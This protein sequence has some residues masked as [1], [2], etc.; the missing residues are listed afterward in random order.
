MA[1]FRDLDQLVLEKISKANMPGVSLAAIK[2]N[3]VIYKRGYGLRDLEKGLPATPA[4]LY[5]IGSVTKSFTCLALMQLQERGLLSVDD[6]VSNHLDF[7]IK[8]FGE[9]VKVRHLM[10]HTSGIPALA[11]AEAVIRKSTGATSRGLSMGSVEDMLTFMEGAGDWAHAKPGERWF[12]L[13]EGYILLGAIIEKVSGLSYQEYVRQHI[14]EPLEME[15]SFFNRESL[16]EDSEAAVPYAIDQEGNRR[17]GEYLFGV[18][19]SDGGLI[20]SVEDLSRY[21]GM[22]LGSGKVDGAQIISE[23]ALQEMMAPRV[24]TPPLQAQ[25]PIDGGAGYRV[26]LSETEPARHYGYGLGM[27]DDFF[28]E[29]VISHGGSVGIATAYMAFV[30]QRSVGIALL[31]N[32]AGYP[33]GYFAEYG[34]AL[35]LG[36]DPEALSFRQAETALDG[37][38][39]TYETFKGTMQATLRRQGDLLLFEAKDK[40]S[41]WRAT[42]IPELLGSDAAQFFRLEGGYRIPVEF[43]ISSDDVEFLF[44]R[45]KFRKIGA[46]TG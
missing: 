42:L 12:Y 33:L 46:L 45:Y 13:N 5:G 34:L 41:N 11:Y 23:G 36:E 4:T 15:R 32:G 20:S 3:E 7:S 21:V 30:P 29:T 27:Q 9:D 16:E 19:S 31:S 14:L 40:L 39:G 25:E 6:K 38:E 10:S 2:D 37:L 1:G 22:F 28:G 43:A 44:E 17:P 26:D 8:P 24:A 35:L 18:I